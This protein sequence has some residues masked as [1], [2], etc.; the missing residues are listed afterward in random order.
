MSMYIQN[1][2]T[3]RWAHIRYTD[4]KKTYT[5]MGRDK[6]PRQKVDLHATYTYAKVITYIVDR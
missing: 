1:R 3:Q 2:L 5:K 6:V 4:K